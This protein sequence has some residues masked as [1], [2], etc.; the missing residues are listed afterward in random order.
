MKKYIIFIISFF[1][2][3]PS[4]SFADNDINYTPSVT[5]RGVFTGFVM[6]NNVSIGEKDES[7]HYD[8]V[9]VSDP[10][11]PLSQYPYGIVQFR[12]P[13]G[14]RASDFCVQPMDGKITTYL[15][16][17]RGANLV[18]TYFSLIPTNTGAV[19]IKNISTGNCLT[20]DGGGIEFPV[21]EKCMLMS[22]QSDKIYKQL[23]FLAPA[24]S[25]S[26]MS[27]LL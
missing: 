21:L 18:G 5:V 17:L 2:I 24:F 4:L 10:S 12:E 11:F 8:L 7:V 1:F 19:L 22:S 6:R 15:C 23:W 26:M 16:S 25:A 3:F 14:F 13:R 9:E 20:S 27:P